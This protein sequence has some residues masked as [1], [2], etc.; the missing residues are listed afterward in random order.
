MGQK[1]CKYDECTSKASKRKTGRK[2]SELA[3]RYK[4][5]YKELQYC[6]PHLCRVQ[7]CENGIVRIGYL[8]CKNH[9]CSIIECKKRVVTNSKFCSAHKC[10]FY[11]CT[12]QKEGL[13]D[14]CSQHKCIIEKCDKIKSKSVNLCNQHKCKYNDY[15]RYDEYY[16]SV[17]HEIPDF[18][19]GVCKK[20]LE[21][22]C[23]I[24]DCY[25]FPKHIPYNR[26][27][28]KRLK[29]CSEHICIFPDCKFSKVRGSDSCN[30]HMCISLGC[31]NIK[32]SELGYFCS[33]CFSSDNSLIFQIIDK[34]LKESGELDSTMKKLIKNAEYI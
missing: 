22:T 27:P 7:D 31:F 20:H 1:I 24:K 17:C 19:T 2:F 6:D 18:T 8:H 14:N 11:G 25:Q 16:Y 10:A 3:G 5:Q 15:Y 34:K 21:E 9:E 28:K 12:S 13:R 4:N 33:D 30:Y 23:Q 29:Y 32:D 26:D